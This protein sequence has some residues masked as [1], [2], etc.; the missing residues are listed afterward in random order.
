MAAQGGK[1]VLLQH[2]LAS[3]KASMDVATILSAGGRRH[4]VMRA[5]RRSQFAPPRA[6]ERVNDR[7]DS[8]INTIRF[9]KGRVSPAS[10]HWADERLA[11]PKKGRGLMS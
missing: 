10:Q 4:S 1:T 3:Q 8:I 7:K 11:S 5:R 6:L 2:M 9:K